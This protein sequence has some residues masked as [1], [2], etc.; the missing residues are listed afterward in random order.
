MLATTAPNRTCC[1]LSTPEHLSRFIGRFIYIYVAK[2][3]LEVSP[4]K[5][6]FRSRSTTFEIPLRAITAID[7]GHYPFWA[8]PL[9][10]DY[11]AV[12]CGAG[13]TKSTVL[14]TPTRAP[15]WSDFPCGC[16]EINRI[17]KK[18]AGILKEASG[19]AS[20]GRGRIRERPDVRCAAIQ[21]ILRPPRACHAARNFSSSR[22]KRVSGRGNGF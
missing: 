21:L 19:A 5:L 8:K 16:M 3:E 18:W 7:V 11:I 2:G 14:L 17:V 22:Q 10:L 9:R 1:H 4:E 20:A 13:A 12:T 6:H 15:R